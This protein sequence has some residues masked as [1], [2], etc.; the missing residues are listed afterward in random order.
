[1]DSLNRN[2][3]H[4][5]IELSTGSEIMSINQWIIGNRMSASSATDTLWFIFVYKIKDK[6]SAFESL[7]PLI[8]SAIYLIHAWLLNLGNGESCSFEL[9][10]DMWRLNSFKDKTTGY[11]KRAVNIQGFH[12]LAILV[13]R[14][15]LHRS[16][17]FR[18][19]QLA[20]RWI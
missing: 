19:F 4:P 1:M 8:Y 13:R 3:I 5:T 14:G 11:C 16:V 18:S 20:K 10:R 12:S 2:F 6:D 7:L 17:A 15:D 9:R